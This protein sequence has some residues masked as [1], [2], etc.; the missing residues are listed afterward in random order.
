MKDTYLRIY[1]N[2]KQQVGLPELSESE[3]EILNATASEV[4]EFFES[5]GNLCCGD[6]NSAAPTYVP[7]G[8]D[9]GYAC[10]NTFGEGPNYVPNAWL[11]PYDIDSLQ[12]VPPNNPCGQDPAQFS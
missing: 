6:G 11:Y 9:T 8:V 10:C 7:Q 5:Q 4:A 1:S 12:F 3:K 2:A